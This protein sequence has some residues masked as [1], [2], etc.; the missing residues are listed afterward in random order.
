M[1]DRNCTLILGLEINVY[2]Y[3]SREDF[4]GRESRGKFTWNYSNLS[5]RNLMDV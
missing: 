4:Q 2:D 5:L 1:C 3:L